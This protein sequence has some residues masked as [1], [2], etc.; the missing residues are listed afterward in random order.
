MA[1]MTVVDGR[2]VMVFKMW[3]DAL[4]DL[5]GH[6]VV[7]VP[8]VYPPTS[9][10]DW[11][12]SLLKPG[13]TLPDN[14]RGTY[15]SV[16]A[17]ATVNGAPACLFGDVRGATL[18]CERSGA[19]KQPGDWSVVQH[20][21]GNDWWL[22]EPFAVTAFDGKPCLACLGFG[23]GEK[24]LI[25][26]SGIRI[27]WPRKSIP[28]STEDME[29]ANVLAIPHQAPAMISNTLSL[30]E[31]NGLPVVAYCAPGATIALPASREKLA[32][33]WAQISLR[34]T[35]SF[36]VGLCICGESLFLLSY[37]IPGKLLLGQCELSKIKQPGSWS[38]SIV[39]KYSISE[40]CRIAAFGDR[41]GVL[42]ARRYALTYECNMCFAFA[43]VAHPSKP[44]DWR[45]S[46]VG[47]ELDCHALAEVDGKPAVFAFSH[48]SVVYA[49]ATRPDPRSN[50][51]WQV[52]AV[53]EDQKS[54]AVR[55]ARNKRWQRHG[56]LDIVDARIFFS[57]PIVYILATAT[58]CIVAFTA[59][60]IVRTRKRR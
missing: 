49:Y 1:G 52:T 22:G 46:V 17:M 58:L 24:G 14:D 48:S 23:I 39:T 57:N 43:K 41:L 26:F 25:K 34:T 59:L 32:E 9:E 29:I 42:Y 20:V 2:P 45:T 12:L 8:Q 53:Y 44:T 18:A 33:P 13:L 15:D 6:L 54:K 27:V 28:E 16:L 31:V 37:E 50:Q 4:P 56:N 47:P 51:D 5:A 3:G 19:P 21:F 11:N 10:Q 7:A 55:I 38:W 40:N 36:N 35:R 30:A 60:F